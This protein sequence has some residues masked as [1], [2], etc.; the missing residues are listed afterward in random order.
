[1]SHSAIVLVPHT[2]APFADCPYLDRCN[3]ALT[4]DSCRSCQFNFASIYAEGCH[5][6]SGSHLNLVAISWSEAAR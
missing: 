4:S 5:P 1:M 3:R 6:D 2:P